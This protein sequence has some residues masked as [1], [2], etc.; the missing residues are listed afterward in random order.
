V[1]QILVGSQYVGGFDQFY[2]Y[3]RDH[4]AELAR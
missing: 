3:V 2:A 1:P 4:Q